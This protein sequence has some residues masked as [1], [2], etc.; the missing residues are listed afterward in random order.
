MTE[1]TFISIQLPFSRPPL[2]LNQRLHWAVK[3][4]ETARIRTLVAYLA[5]GKTITPPCEVELVWTVTDK[6]RR[7]LDNAAPTTKACTDGLR[8]AGA[9]PDDHS[10][11]VVKSGCRIEIGSVKGLRLEVR[12][13]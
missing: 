7:D 4:R 8:D 6:R 10:G 5:R 12:A 9:I 11:I 3:A 2:N 1:H 13:A